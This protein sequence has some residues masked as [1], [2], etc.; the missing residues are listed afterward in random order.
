MKKQVKTKH[1]IKPYQRLHLELEKILLSKK[2]EEKLPSEP[3]LAKRLGVSRATLR[4]AMRSFEGQGMIRRRQGIGTFVVGGAPV[5]EAGLE[6]LESIETLANRIDLKVT[7]GALDVSRRA[8]DE[9]QAKMLNVP[10]GESLVQ[11]ERVIF[12][13]LRPVAF[14]H[15]TLAENVLTPEELQE[16]FNGSVLDFMLR[17][18]KQDLRY[19]HTDISAVGATHDIARALQIQR[20]DVLLLLTSILYTKDGRAV[21]YSKSYFIPGYFHFHVIRKLSNGNTK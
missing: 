2:P 9:D 3:T 15:D 13:D 7:M 12:T 11:V 1:I 8:A 21:D 10:Q 16:G 6:V 4:E 18:G 17:R 19:S 14:L 5:I 20:G